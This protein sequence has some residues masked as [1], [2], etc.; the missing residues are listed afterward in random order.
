[1][2]TVIILLD[3]IFS[4]SHCWLGQELLVGRF[5][6]NG[7]GQE[8]GRVDDEQCVTGGVDEFQVLQQTIKVD[9]I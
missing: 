6:V 9:V 2:N 1:M 4:T 3:K 8:P 5:C 7:A